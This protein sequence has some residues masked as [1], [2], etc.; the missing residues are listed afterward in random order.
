MALTTDDK[1]ILLS[2]LVIV[3]ALVVY[4]EL[5]VMRGKAKEV[6]IASQRK[7]GAHNSILTTRSII[8]VVERE[9]ADVS[10]ARAVFLRAR[11]AMARGD[12]DRA[13]DLCESARMEL[14]A[15]RQGRGEPVRAVRKPVRADEGADD[16]EQL[17]DEIIGSDRRSPHVDSYKGAKLAADEGSGFLS[18][19]F[20]ITAAKDDVG[21]SAER[22]KDIGKAKSFLKQ[23]ESEFESGN[24][25]K[26]L[27]LA[28]KARKELAGGASYDTIPLKVAVKPQVAGECTEDVATM[29][30]DRARRLKCG[31]CSSMV[32]PD[33]VFCGHCGAPAAK[34]RECVKCGRLSDPKDRFCRK[35]GTEL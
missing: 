8:D 22:G 33:D 14:L 1:M 2:V 4:Y 25:P 13:T 20:E 15:C 26:A 18:A 6:R 12:Y 31:S 24:Y 11:D 17:A 28:V 16:L 3:M 29:T 30:D 27:S 23:A 34:E 35:C 10:A 7:D 19:K 21:A 5:K 9:G 32:L